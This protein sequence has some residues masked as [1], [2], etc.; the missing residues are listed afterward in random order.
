MIWLISY[1]FDEKS[2][3]HARSMHGQLNHSTT[4]L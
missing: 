1:W 2:L 3:A 4:I